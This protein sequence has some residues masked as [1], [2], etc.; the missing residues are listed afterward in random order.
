MATENLNGWNEWSRY[1]LKELERLNECYDK[2][3]T[4]LDDLKTSNTTMKVQMGFIGGVSGLV[5]SAII[6]LLIKYMVK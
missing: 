1:V 3:T 2:Q 4:K 6:S 5:V